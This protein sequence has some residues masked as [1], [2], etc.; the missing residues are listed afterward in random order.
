MELEPFFSAGGDSFVHGKYLSACGDDIHMQDS[1]GIASPDNRAGIVRILHLLQDNPEV[2][3]PEGENSLDFLNSFFCRHRKNIAKRQL[4][5]KS[6][7][8]MEIQNRMIFPDKISQRRI[9][10]MMALHSLFFR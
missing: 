3:L 4:K 1:C 2:R 9:V 8:L 5:E 6:T 10:P 7:F